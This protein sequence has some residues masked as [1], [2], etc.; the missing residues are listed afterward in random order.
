MTCIQEEDWECHRL[1]CA[2]T[3]KYLVNTAD[4]IFKNCSIPDKS[5]LSLISSYD[6]AEI[7]GLAEKWPRTY[8]CQLETCPECES[9]LSQLETRRQKNRSDQKLLITKLN[10]VVVDI[11]SKRCKNCHILYQPETLAYGLLNIGD[12]TLVSVDIFFSLRSTIR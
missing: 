9:Q 11:L 7:L 10:M 8:A 2:R 4:Y 6:S 5:I 12:V 1:E 3:Q